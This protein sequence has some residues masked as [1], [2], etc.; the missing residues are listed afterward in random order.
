MI[1]SEVDKFGY[2]L[3]RVKIQN[4]VY[5]PI[6]FRIIVTTNCNWLITARLCIIFFFFFVLNARYVCIIRNSCHVQR[7]YVY[8]F[9]PYNV[10]RL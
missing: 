8:I 10:N 6:S 3:A 9:H 4:K 1:T 5:D 2:C 7:I